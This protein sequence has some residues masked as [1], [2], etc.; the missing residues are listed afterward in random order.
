[1]RVDFVVNWIPVKRA[2]EA[3]QGKFYLHLLLQ[4]GNQPISNW[5]SYFYWSSRRLENFESLTF[6]FK[7]RI[8]GIRYSD[9]L[10]ATD[11]FFVYSTS[12][13]NTESWNSHNTHKDKVNI[14]VQGYISIGVFVNLLHLF[15]E[16]FMERRIFPDYNWHIFSW[17]HFSKMLYRDK[18]WSPFESI[19]PRLT[20]RRSSSRS[21]LWHKR[22]E[23][24]STL[25]SVS[26]I[27]T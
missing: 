6:A 15:Q 19:F 16:S 25:D 27:A 22:K 24:I 3:S 2:L 26:K 20:E 23:T 14:S 21:P 10:L 18:L 17:L 12:T 4:Q 7:L 5:I 13:L 1:M 8:L 11:V 9:A